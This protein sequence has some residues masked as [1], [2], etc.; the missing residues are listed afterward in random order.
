[1]LI[2]STSVTHMFL[3]CSCY[4]YHIP[5]HSDQSVCYRENHSDSDYYSCWHNHNH[6]T[7]HY[8]LK[9]NKILNCLGIKMVLCKPKF[10]IYTIMFIYK[11]LIKLN[12]I[13][14]ATTFQLMR[15]ICNKSGPVQTPNY[16]DLNNAFY[17]KC[18]L[19]THYALNVINSVLYTVD[20]I[21][22]HTA[23]R[24]ILFTPCQK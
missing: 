7:P 24:C 5:R 18:K 3:C 13:R 10:P 12:L 1:M 11:L 20:C 21:F 17:E 6:R 14:W 23:P 19:N 2:F 22:H 16:L 15:R 4:P 9:K 8:I